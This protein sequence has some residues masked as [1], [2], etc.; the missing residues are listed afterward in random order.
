MWQ[1]MRWPLLVV[2]TA[3]IALII[4]RIPAVGEKQKTAEA[5]AYIRAQKITLDDVEATNLPPAPDPL[6]NNATVAGIDANHNGIRD[7]VELA[8]FKEYPNSPKIRAAELQ[9]ALT[10]QMFLTKVYNAGTWKAVAEEAARAQLCII[11]TKANRKE[12]E[13]LIFNTQSRNDAREK[14]YQFTTSYGP[15]SGEPCDIL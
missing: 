7:D 3:Y 12:V 2:G 14:A 4:Y 6:K 15:A 11:D 10:E 9:Y 13:N 1:V 8:I 5:V